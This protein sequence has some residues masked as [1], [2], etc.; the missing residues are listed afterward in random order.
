MIIKMV[1]D[2]IMIVY[3]FCSCPR[4]GLENIGNIITEIIKKHCH[5]FV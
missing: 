3:E 2:C 1:W 4:F 5:L